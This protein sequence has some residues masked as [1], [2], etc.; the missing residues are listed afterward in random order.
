LEAG[1]VINS[2]VAPAAVFI[3]FT[4]LGEAQN[5]YVGITAAGVSLVNGVFRV[6]HPKRA[7]LFYIIL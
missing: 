3:E 4:G 2:T 1:D 5:G 6:S 7:R